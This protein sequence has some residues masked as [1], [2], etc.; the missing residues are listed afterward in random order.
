MNWGAILTQLQN[1]G[2]DERF[3]AVPKSEEVLVAQVKIAVTAG[4]VDLNPLLKQATVRRPIVEQ[5]I[6][7]WKDA[8]HADFGAV[9]M[10][11]VSPRVTKLLRRDTDEPTVPGCIL[12]AF[13]DDEEDG[14]ADTETDKA[15]TPAER[16]WSEA[17]LARDMDRATPQYMLL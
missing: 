1:L 11:H 13:P 15:A 10:T 6:R 2:R 9:N 17:A 5:L 14:P 7:M 4:L 16:N 3:R 8:G 12:D